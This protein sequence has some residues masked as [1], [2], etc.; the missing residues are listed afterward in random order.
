MVSFLSFG[1]WSNNLLGEAGPQGLSGWEMDRTVCQ[2]TH[3]Q[4]REE[5]PKAE[6]VRCGLD[7]FDEPVKT[8]NMWSESTEKQKK[9][10][11]FHPK[12][13]EDEGD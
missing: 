11:F 7:L 4:V 13:N 6:R 2:N 3:V 8:M 12:Q 10:V 5:K 9:I 1:G